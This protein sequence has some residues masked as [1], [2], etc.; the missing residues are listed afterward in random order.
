MKK[1]LWLMPVLALMACN[2]DGPDNPNVDPSTCPVDTTANRGDDAGDFVE[3]QTWE[4]AVSV[5]WDGAAA[6]VSGQVDGVS[7]SSENGYVVVTSTAKHVEYNLS[8]KGTGQMKIYSDYKFRIN[9][10]GLTLTCSNGPA[11]NNQGN[12]TCYIVVSGTNVL[13]DGS[14]YATSEESQKSA[15]FS[16]GQLVFTGTGVLDITGNYKHALASD[17]YI[18]IREGEIN[19]TATVS[20]GL[21]ANDGI[22]IDGGKLIVSAAGDGMQC[23]TSSVVVTGGNVTITKAGDKGILAY[24][25]ILILGGTVVVH[26]ADKGIK[27]QGNLLVEGGSVMVFAGSDSAQAAYAG[28]GGGPGGHGGGPGGGPGGGGESSGAEGIEAKGDMA[29]MGGVV[30]AQASDDAINSG[31]DMYLCGGMVCAYSTGNDGIDANGNCYIQDGLVYAI[32]AGSPEM[33]IDANSE[34]QKKLYLQGG[35]LV[36]IGGLES[37]AEL[38][39]TCYWTNTWNKSTWYVL[40]AGNDMFAFKTPASG[41]SSLIVSPPTAPTLLSGVTVTGGDPIFNDMG[42]L[43]AETMDGSLVLL[44]E[45][46]GES[47]GPGGRPW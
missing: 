13:E 18:R 27:T 17:D 14:T 7:V 2:T 39:Q 6:S 34:A 5:V 19:L 8:G 26:S 47:G 36:A 29:L 31:G 25:N 37:G 44:D 4:S 43:D 42:Y 35:T 33:A 20:D 45:Y 16:E 12:K 38:E 23:D 46:E 22:I 15:F 24:G 1:L 10:N 28:P 32:G 30:Y 40:S 9:L 41:G 21:H 11:I 3:N